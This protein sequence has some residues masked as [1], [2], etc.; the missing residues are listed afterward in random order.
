LTF[1]AGVFL[2]DRYRVDASLVTWES[3]DVLRVPTSALFRFDSR[4]SVFV[5]EAGRARR[6][7]VEL[8]HQGRGHAEVHSGLSAGDVVIVHPSEAVQDGA[9]VQ[10][11]G[12]LEG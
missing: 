3:D 7:E 4:W 2:G 10:A 6:R 12:D 9:R 1:D 8:G 11:A 5:V